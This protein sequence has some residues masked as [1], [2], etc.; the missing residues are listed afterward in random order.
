[1]PG[2]ARPGLLYITA[3]TTRRAA[4]LHG[5]RCVGG[6]HVHGPVDEGARRESCGEFGRCATSSRPSAMPTSS[7]RR[8]PP[9]IATGGRGN[10]AR[11]QRRG[12]R[13]ITA[14]RKGSRGARPRCSPPWAAPSP[15]RGGRVDARGRDTNCRHPLL[16][17]EQAPRTQRSAFGRGWPMPCPLRERRRVPK[18]LG[19]R[20]GSARRRLVRPASSSGWRRQRSGTRRRDSTQSPHTPAES[21]GRCPDAPRLRLS[22]GG[23]LSADFFWGRRGLMFASFDGHDLTRKRW[24]AELFAT[25]S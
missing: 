16:L 2:A 12:H 1:M 10:L 6:R 20:E 25:T 19:M 21:E 8:D 24:R 15:R 7:A 3:R 13:A 23:L 17:W 18:L 14:A 11:P 5:E 4:E 22:P 9:A